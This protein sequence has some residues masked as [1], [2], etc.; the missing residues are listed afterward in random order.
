MTASASAPVR[1]FLLMLALLAGLG[2]ALAVKPEEQLPDPAAEARARQ[3]SSGLRC[4]VCQNQSIDDSDAGLAQDL[5]RLVRERITAGDSDQAIREFLVARYGEF[6]LLK[7]S[8]TVQTLLLWGLPAFA[9]V[10]GAGAALS[11]FRRSP[12]AREDSAEEAAAP[13]GLSE[14]ERAELENLL[15]EAPIAQDRRGG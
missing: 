10:L 4:L 12:K 14:A 11:L 6:V 3:I 15:S 5:R 2:P 8:F 9:L 13:D 7:P 1:A